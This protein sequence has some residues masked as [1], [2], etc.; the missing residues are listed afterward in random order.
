[1]RRK[2]H[3]LVVGDDVE[4]CINLPTDTEDEFKSQWVDKRATIVE[5]GDERFLIHFDTDLHGP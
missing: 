1:M 2:A 5:V 3:L 4:L